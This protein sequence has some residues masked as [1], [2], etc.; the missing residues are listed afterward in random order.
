MA[1][2][3]LNA[4][5]YARSSI[6][7]ELPTVLA[8]VSLRADALEKLVEQVE[9]ID[10][11]LGKV[12]QRYDE[13]LSPK[14]LEGIEAR[15]KNAKELLSRIDPPQADVQAAKGLIDEA[16]GSLEKIGQPD[17]GFAK[18]LA[19]RIRSLQD[20]KVPVDPNAPA[21]QV[22]VA[23]VQPFQDFKDILRDLF[24]TVDPYQREEAIKP[25]DY[26]RWDVAVTKI[27]LIRDYA[28]LY[29]A[30]NAE[31]KLKLEGGQSFSACIRANAL[32]SLRSAKRV[33]QHMKDGVFPADIKAAILDTG[34]PP[35]IRME[36]QTAR[37]Y[38]PMYFS[39]HFPKPEHN[40]CAALEDVQCEWDLGHLELK[41]QGWRIW[42]YFP[43]VANEKM[44][45]TV[46]ATFADGATGE[47][48]PTKKKIDKKFTVI[49][50]R[51]RGFGDRNW[52]ELV[53]LSIALMVALLGLLA[54]AREQ[55]LKLDLIPAAVAVFSL[56]FGADT[57]KNLL[58][59]KEK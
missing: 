35:S 25:E 11:L 29:A 27:E 34:N 33:V 39:I 43:D 54:G 30:L 47:K 4:E 58:V 32:A 48:I 59:P 9:E 40:S 3:R 17:P 42:H 5:L 15:L 52:A 22:G 36:P 21:A 8:A 50:E 45:Q 57:I 37:Q 10:R 41:E 18:A 31:A 16:K 26:G 2:Q 49:A 46:E 14:Q 6:S 28:M 53:R 23:F 38:S 55:L 19:G 7:A 20:M 56:G 13:G 51:A 24:K 44:P 12:E 1:R